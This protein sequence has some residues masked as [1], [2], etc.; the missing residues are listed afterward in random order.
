MTKDHNGKCICFVELN[1]NLGQKLRMMLQIGEIK[2]I[3]NIKL[4]D[5][6]WRFP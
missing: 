1:S 4:F 6:K 3:E 2:S 5:R